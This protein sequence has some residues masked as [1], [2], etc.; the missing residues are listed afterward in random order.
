M[1]SSRTLF[2]DF[3]TV[4]SNQKKSS[5]LNQ[6]DSFSGEGLM[7]WSGT[8]LYTYVGGAIVFDSRMRKK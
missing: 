1:S 4:E 7:I 5:R 8:E 2:L 6:E 3:Q